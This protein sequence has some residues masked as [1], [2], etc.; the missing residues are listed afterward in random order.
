MAKRQR[1]VYPTN[2]IPHLWAHQ[3]QYDA[4][5]GRGNLYFDGPTIYS[6][7]DSFPIATIVTVGRKKV[8]LL[9]TDTYSVTTG[10]HISAVRQSIPKGIRVF[11]VPRVLANDIEGHKD[12]LAHYILEHGGMLDKALKSAHLGNLQWR[13][14]SAIILRDEG[15]RYA[16][17]FKVKVSDVG[18]FRVYPPN[19]VLD[20]L[21][22][23]AEAREKASEARMAAKREHEQAA[24]KRRVEL[25][26][27]ALPEKI[28][29]W[30]QGE[31]VH[32]G[33]GSVGS[34]IPS[35][36]LRLSKDKT[37]VETSLGARFPVDHAR[38]ALRIITKVMESR[39]EYVKNGHTIHLGHYSLDRIEVDGTVHAGCHVVKWDEIKRLIPQLGEATVDLSSF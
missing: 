3:T 2:E 35:I 12:N 4:R 31:P 27:L 39:Q 16:H 22:V 8:V 7:R 29:K 25:E 26:R 11:N 5:N 20:T 18:K 9:T 10:G 28:E 6:Y 24:W 36:M 34:G 32:F 19:K 1:H 14:R 33:Y 13:L 37:E 17:L 15:R 38:L 23:K 21:R 30:R